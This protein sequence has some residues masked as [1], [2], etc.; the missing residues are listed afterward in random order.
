MNMF[1]KGKAQTSNDYYEAYKSV[2]LGLEEKKEGMFS[3]NNI[4]KLEFATLLAGLIFMGY[5][6]FFN[7]VASLLKEKSLNFNIAQSSYSLSLP[8]S[9]QSNLSDEELVEELNDAETDIVLPVEIKEERELENQV[10][11]L[12]KQL[13]VKPADIALL[14]EIIKSNVDSQ[15]T[16]TEDSIIIS[17]VF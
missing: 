4:I 9:I 5:N 1:K 12:T 15:P 8:L 7:D 2:E 3:L 16:Q 10:E 14:V 17:Q 13:N 6:N 11:Y